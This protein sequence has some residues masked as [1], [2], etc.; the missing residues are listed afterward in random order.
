MEKHEALFFVP[1]AEQLFDLNFKNKNHS[2][3]NLLNQKKNQIKKENN[4]L[5]DKINISSIFQKPKINMNEKKIIS[6]EKKNPIEKSDNKISSLNKIKQYLNEKSKNDKLNLSNSKKLNN[7]NSSS[8]KKIINSST[9]TKKDYSKDKEFYKNSNKHFEGNKTDFSERKKIIPKIV[10]ENLN[11]KRFRDNSPIK[12]KKKDINKKN[13]SNEK[14]NSLSK[15]YQI[16]KS[17]KEK[18]NN[19]KIQQKH[20]NINNN[21]NNNF[22]NK[23]NELKHNININESLDKMINKKKNNNK[24]IL[25]KFESKDKKPIIKNKPINP[26]KK[27]LPIINKNKPISKK[28]SNQINN[29]NNIKNNNKNLNKNNS[30]L[31]KETINKS[32]LAK[33]NAVKNLLNIKKEPEKNNN[34]NKI[35]KTNKNIEKNI[36]KEK[37]KIKNGN[38]FINEDNRKKEDKYDKI[39][40]ANNIFKTPLKSKNINQKA[41]YK[42][43]IEEDKYDLTD[44]FIDDNDIKEEDNYLVRKNINYINKKFTR[45]GPIYQDDDDDD[46]VVEVGFDHIQKLENNTL[47]IGKMEDEKEKREERNRKNKSHNF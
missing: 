34:N 17:T 39:K 13:N 24:T 1:I 6:P 7:Y 5:K 22:N 29:N 46:V 42:H 19:D 23:L 26:I 21:N 38:V 27:P 8:E 32:N 31:E 25:N 40:E 11:K 44:D 16:A 3:S 43:Y 30:S 47:I 10:N 28:N 12:D 20:K 37:S 36:N 9:N 18:T 45:G 33:L 2:N 15:S 35:I 4:N 14:E 41:K